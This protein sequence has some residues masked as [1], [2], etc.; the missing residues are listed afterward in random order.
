MK[1]T[2]KKGE[3]EATNF[4]FAD[5][6]QLSGQSYVTLEMVDYP[7]D[8][9]QYYLVIKRGNN[10]AIINPDRSLSANNVAQY[11]NQLTFATPDQMKLWTYTANTAVENKD[12]ISCERS[13]Y[14]PL[15]E[16]IY[17]IPFERKTGGEEEKEQ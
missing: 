16:T 14:G 4:W 10:Y 12:Q 9:E 3:G 6:N 13:K 8:G 5:A 1:L 17:R 15:N 2:G 7:V 11:Q